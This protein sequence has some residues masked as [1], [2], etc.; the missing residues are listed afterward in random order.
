MCAGIPLPDL[1]GMSFSAIMLSMSTAYQKRKNFL[2]QRASLLVAVA[3]VFTDGVVHLRK[4][5]FA[6]SV[7][8]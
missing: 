6:K 2:W 4:I 7:N 8:N 1:I 5:Y 3:Q